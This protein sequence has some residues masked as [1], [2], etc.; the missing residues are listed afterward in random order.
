MFILASAN[1]EYILSEPGTSQL[2]WSNGKNAD[3]LWGERLRVSREQIPGYVYPIKVLQHSA[4]FPFRSLI[5][6]V[7]AMDLASKPS[8]VVSQ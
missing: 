3:P 4:T 6:R 5:P 8:V 1:L 7:S 2:R